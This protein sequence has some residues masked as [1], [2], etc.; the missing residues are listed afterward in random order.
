MKSTSQSTSSWRIRSLR[1]NTA[2]FSTPTSSSS[3]AR[4]VA[5]DLLGQLGRGARARRAGPG[6]RRSPESSIGRESRRT[7][8][9]TGSAQA[10]R[11]RRVACEALVTATPATH[12]ISPPT[13]TTGSSPRS[14]RGT[15]RSVKRSWSDLVP[16][17]PSGRMRSPSRQARTVTR[18]P[19]AAASTRPRRPGARAA[20][21]S[22]APKR[23]L[24]GTA[25]S[26]GSA[27]RA[28]RAEREAHRSVLGH[29]PQAAAEVER[30][31]ALVGRARAPPRRR[32]RERVAARRP[33][34]RRGGGAPAA[35][36]ARAE[37]GERGGVDGGPAAERSSAASTARC[38]A[39]RPRRAAG[40][41]VSAIVCSALRARAPAA[42][43]AARAAR[44]RARSGG[45]CWTGPRATGGRGRGSG[46]A[47]R[48]AGHGEQRPHEPA[49][50][51]AIPQQ[52][53]PAGRDGQPVEHGLG[54]VGGGVGG[55]VVA[56]ACRS[57]SA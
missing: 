36:S 48:A 31:T 10:S 33:R 49:A 52:R 8:R 26:T 16:P 11:S 2:P 3:T 47:S 7:R 46:R 35:R 45:R 17:R 29:R 22:Q 6:S 9:S 23:T 57:A 28:S 37:R 4:V 55:G 41:T 50:P 44:A 43:R 54:L 5:R 18:A 30:A 1:K 34:A 40:R 53:A 27:A 14:A 32:A 20:S 13:S 42:R 15:L 56:A 21:T 19:T 38:R 24:P 25:S 12:T 39:P 51:G